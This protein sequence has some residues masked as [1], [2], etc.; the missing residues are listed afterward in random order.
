MR[1]RPD[2]P[3]R[4]Q[5]VSTPPRRKS[6]CPMQPLAPS[7][8][9][10]P[11]SA[12]HYLF[13]PISGSI[14]VSRSTTI[15]AMAVSP[16]YSN[17]AVVNGKFTIQAPHQPSHQRRDHTPSPR[18][19]PYPISPTARSSTTQPMEPPRPPHPR[20]MRRPFVVS[21]STTIK[22]IAT[23]PGFDVSPRA[24][25]DSPSHPR[26][27][28]PSLRRPVSILPRRTSP[29]PTQPAELSSTTQRISVPPPPLQRGIRVPSW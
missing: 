24:A 13:D 12:H 5:R 27:D 29:Y 2:Q 26:P 3:S 20:V 1:L 28:P 11:I 25:D 22:A 7:S 17:S 15:R 18:M 21:L 6:R 16:G 23:A 4:L 19:S 8:T 14:L 10:R 9:T